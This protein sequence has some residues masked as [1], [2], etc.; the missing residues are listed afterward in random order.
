MPNYY[1]N[2][3]CNY[4]ARNCASGC[5]TSSGY[6]ATSSSTCYYRY[7]DYY[8]NGNYDFSSADDEV[9]MIIFKSTAPIWG[10]YLG[11]MVLFVIGAIVCYCMRKKW[12]ESV[13]KFDTEK[14]KMIA[15][16]NGDPLPLMSS[17]VRPNQFS[18]THY[19]Q[20]F[21]PGQHPQTNPQMQNTF[22]HLKVHNASL[23]LNN[24]SLNDNSRVNNQLVS[25]GE[26]SIAD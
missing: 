12:V 1:Y 22:T 6:C 19:G 16:I 3:Y 23:S 18:S 25:R 17:A 11:Y 9:S 24:A 4:S 20:H 21:G 26:I 8:S 10:A 5:C 7:Y 13:S 2:S 15:Y 14:D